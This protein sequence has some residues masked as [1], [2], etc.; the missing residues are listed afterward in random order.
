MGPLWPNYNTVATK[1]IVF[2]DLWKNGCVFSVRKAGSEDKIFV[3]TD[4]NDL[5]AVI[6]VLGSATPTAENK[7]AMPT[8]SC[9]S[10]CGRI[11]NGCYYE[12]EKIPPNQ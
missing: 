2:D 5:N 6:K 1:P 9:T 3:V 11:V 7:D 4:P 12:I 10:Y 8:I